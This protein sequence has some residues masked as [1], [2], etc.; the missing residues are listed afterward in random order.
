MKHLFSDIGQQKAMTLKGV[1][2]LQGNFPNWHR[3]ELN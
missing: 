3:E 1:E 2:F